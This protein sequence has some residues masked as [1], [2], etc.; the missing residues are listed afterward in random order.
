MFLAEI[1]GAP[2]LKFSDMFGR[3]RSAKALCLDLV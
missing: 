2:S 1:S 3:V